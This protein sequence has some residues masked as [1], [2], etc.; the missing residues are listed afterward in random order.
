MIHTIQRIKRKTHPNILEGERGYI[1]SSTSIEPIH[2]DV[3]LTNQISDDTIISKIIPTI[4]KHGNR[5]EVIH[6]I[7][8][9]E[10]DSWKSMALYGNMGFYIVVPILLGLFIG[11]AVDDLTGKKP[12]FTLVCLGFGTVSGIYNLIRTL[13]K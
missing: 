9:R 2:E 13:K 10:D 7:K 5:T 12:L 3:H 11:I 4:D 8:K 1:S 6:K